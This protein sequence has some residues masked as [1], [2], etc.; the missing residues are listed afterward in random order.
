MHGSAVGLRGRANRKILAIAGCT[1]ERWR[2]SAREDVAMCRL[3]D[4]LVV[5]GQAK[6]LSL[7]APEKK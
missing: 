6:K 7:L 4:A 1:S 5:V 3:L 2:S